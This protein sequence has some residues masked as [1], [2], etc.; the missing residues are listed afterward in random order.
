MNIIDEIK[1]GL[2]ERYN[3][4]MWKLSHYRTFCQRCDDPKM[5]VYYKDVNMWLC[6]ECVIETA[7]EKGY[8]NG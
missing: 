8:I 4:L 7:K 3:K 2:K 5:A 1:K 6:D